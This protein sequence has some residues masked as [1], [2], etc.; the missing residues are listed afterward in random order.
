MPGTIP[1]VFEQVTLGSATLRNRTIKAATFEGRAPLGLVTDELV[2]F[3]RQFA[4]GGVGMTTLAFCGVTAD[5]KQFGPMIE[6][7]PETRPGLRRLTDAVHAEGAAASVQIGHA[8]VVAN[9]K[10]TGVPAIGPVKRFDVQNLRSCRAATKADLIRVVRAFGEATDVAV[11][12]GF[13]AVEVHLGHDY[14]PSSFLNPAMNKREDEYGGSL[15]NRARLAREITRTVREHAKGRLAVIAKLTMDDG[16]PGGFWID[17]A[18]QVAQWLEADGSVDAIELTRGS[19]PNNT[20]YMFRG[21]PPLR[22]FAA[23]MPQPRKLMVQVGGRLKLKSYP[24]EPLFM[25]ETARQVRAAVDLPLILLGGITDRAHM[26]QALADGFEFVAMGRALLRE[27]DL[28]NRI[29]AAP[30]HRSLCI[31]CNKCMP[32]IFAG[33]THCVLAR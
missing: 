27:P 32:T 18:I 6:M 22:E 21:D 13:D 30:G 10:S 20:M 15:V 26:D 31:H 11:E 24:Y 8:G 16:V 4:A 3:H 23:A 19:S 7:R 17:E 14:L 2:D 12:S 33:G 28:V 1:E 9:P 29:Q 5:G 25:L